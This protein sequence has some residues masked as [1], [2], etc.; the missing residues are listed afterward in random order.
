MR[1]LIQFAGNHY[2]E[3][4]SRELEIH[5]SAILSI[6]YVPHVDPDKNMKYSGRRYV[7]SNKDIESIEYSAKSSVDA[8]N[9]TSLLDA[10]EKINK[11]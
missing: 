3:V 1:S 6:E 4:S 8:S 10:L 5:D 2:R 7:I 9:V 11:E